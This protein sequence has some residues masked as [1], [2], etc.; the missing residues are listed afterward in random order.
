MQ[1]LC[2]CVCGVGRFW[3]RDNHVL[4]PSLLGGVSSGMVLTRG[5]LVFTGVKK[6]EVG[7]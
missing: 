3:F 4:I 6:G 7:I 1:Q 5:F 2:V